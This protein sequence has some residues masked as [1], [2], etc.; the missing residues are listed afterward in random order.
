M[1]RK[2]SS[3]TKI[4]RS[5]RSHGT[6]V[7]SW[8]PSP[9]LPVL[10]YGMWNNCSLPEK[11]HAFCQMWKWAPGTCVTSLWD[12]VKLLTVH[13]LPFQ[14]VSYMTIS[15]DSKAEKFPL[16]CFCGYSW[17]VLQVTLQ[18][19]PSLKPLKDSELEQESGSVTI[20]LIIFIILAH[21]RNLLG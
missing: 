11:E 17:G 8:D 14:W 16:S 13:W 20:S 4:M 18:T 5:G 19:N 21:I 1:L 3:T 9:P 7:W 2:T 12:S 15:E 6:T 10:F